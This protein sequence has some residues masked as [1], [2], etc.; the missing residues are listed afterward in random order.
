MVE[1]LKLSEKTNPNKLW[2]LIEMVLP[3]VNTNFENM[4]ESIQNMK[5]EFENLANDIKDS[6]LE[7]IGGAKTEMTSAVK[8]RI[9]NNLI[10]NIASL[11][12]VFKTEVRNLCSSIG[13]SLM[14]AP[15]RV[16]QK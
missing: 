13:S 9:K 2:M 5:F 15:E 4:N 12:K 8:E 10:V 14:T 11:L 6:N 7:I 3:Y 16:L 1:H